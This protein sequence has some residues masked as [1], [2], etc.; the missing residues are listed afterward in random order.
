[1][2]DITLPEG[3]AVIE[4]GAFQ[5]CFSLRSVTIYA[6]VAAIADDAFEGTSLSTI[7]GEAGS[8]AQAYAETHGICFVPI[9]HYNPVNYRALLITNIEFGLDPDGKPIADQPNAAINRDTMLAV[10]P[11]FDQ[12]IQIIS[13]KNVEFGNIDNLIRNTFASADDNDVSIIYL[14]S[15]G[16]NDS[17]SSRYGWMQ[18]PG[19]Y[20][21]APS[22]LKNTLSNL[23]GTY[24]I[25]ADYCGSGLVAET[26][27][28]E[29]RIIAF[30]ACG[31]SQLSHGGKDRASFYTRTLGEA[32][33]LSG[34]I[35]AD[36]DGN[37]L[38]VKE[39]NDYLNEEME[40]LQNNMAVLET[41]GVPIANLLTVFAWLS[42]SE[43]QT[44]QCSHPNS[45]LLLFTRN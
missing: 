41:W 10:L 36:K 29:D 21:Y 8:N 40:K 17:A 19:G 9:Q 11:T 3:L 15:H 35:P 18:T 22:N 16:T 34:R 14:T 45:E 26:F 28:N 32:L 4:S 6:S 33:G 30:S 7:F 27:K 5:D 23:K 43:I 31:Q 12:N 24:I 1:M 20:Y 39:L 2:L 13:R 25:I 38:T 42:Q 44:P 37:G